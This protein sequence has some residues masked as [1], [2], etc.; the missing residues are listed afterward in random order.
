MYNVIFC[1]FMI[2]LIYSFMTLHHILFKNWQL[3]YFTSYGTNAIVVVIQ[4]DFQSMS[5]K[6]DHD[7]DLW[8]ITRQMQGTSYSSYT[9]DHLNPFSYLLVSKAYGNSFVLNCK[10]AYFGMRDFKSLHLQLL[11]KKGLVFNNERR[12]RKGKTLI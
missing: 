2:V 1:T 8:Q 4:Q 6:S 3:Q 12:N 9:E 7:W 11:D 10:Q 5:Q